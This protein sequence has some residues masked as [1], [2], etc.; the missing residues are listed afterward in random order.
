MSCLVRFYSFPQTLIIVVHKK[1]FQPHN[2]FNVNYVV[3]IA[4][5]NS[6]CLLGDQ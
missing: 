1:N 5:T 6:S 3:F 4:T 2:K